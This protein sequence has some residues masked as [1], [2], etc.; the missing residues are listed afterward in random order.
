MTQTYRLPQKL[1]SFQ[2]RMYI[3]LI[4]WKWKHVTTERGAYNYKGKSYEYDAILPKSD[5]E[6][7]P[8]I[9]PP[10]LSDL[11]K[12]KA[13]FDFKFHEHFNHMASSQAANANLFLP[14]LLHP[15][16]NDIFKQL[17]PNFS[18]LA[19]DELYKGFRIEFWDG[20]S[21]LE[22]GILKDHSAIAG[23]D[24]DIAIAYYNTADE[25]CLW[26]VEHKLTEAEF[27]VCGGYKS[28]G[29]NPKRH[30]CEKSF[31]AIIRNKEL[32]YYH[33]GSK[34]EYWNITEAN[35]SFF[36]NQA[37]H[38]SCPFKEGMNQLWRNQLLGFA[39]EKQG[40]YKHVHFSVVHHHD[41]HSL[42]KSIADYKDLI[43]N[44]P[45]FSLLTSADVVR[46]AS[47]IED[48]DLGQWIEWYK[49]LYMV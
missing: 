35:Q 46:A 39:I 26:L 36:V 40:K 7:F 25:L 41:N 31:S 19:T 44:N 11:K 38:I 43:G 5:H 32:C 13:K 30:L 15:K 9:Y 33:D 34:F 21:N 17:I 23:T 6:S 3:H 24:S 47:N 28:K 18:R 12:L 49:E 45:K 14:I 1:N 8:I 22:K 16:A 2:E 42:C 37:K 27:T 4:E 48:G 20:N 10:A 29:R